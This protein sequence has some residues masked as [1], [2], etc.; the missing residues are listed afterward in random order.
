MIWKVSRRSGKCP[1]HPDNVYWAYLNHAYAQNLAKRICRKFESWRNL[2]ALSGKFLRQKPCYPESFRFLWLCQNGWNFGNAP[3]ECQS[4][5]RPLAIPVRHVH[6][7]K[8]QNRSLFF[9]SLSIIT[10]SKA[11]FSQNGSFLPGI[12]FFRI[13]ILRRWFHTFFSGFC[14]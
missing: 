3:S 11:L 9:C 1:D 8:Y 7:F 13:S 6:K 12:S 2:R 10:L 14:L 5:K 4:I